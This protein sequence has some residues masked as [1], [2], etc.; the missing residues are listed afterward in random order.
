MARP[1]R[2]ASA[3]RRTSPANPKRPATGEH[4]RQTVQSVRIDDPLLIDAFIRE[5]QERGIDKYDEIWEGVYVVPPL[6]NLPHQDLALAL[7]VILYNVVVLEDRGRVQAG[8]NVSDRREDWEYNCRVPD[9]V[10]V[11][12]EGRAVAC[13]T[14]WMGG[15]DFLIEIK[16][17]GDETEEKIPFY[18]KLKVRELLIIHRDTRELRLYRHN[19]RKL[20][21]VKAAAH[22]GG[23]WLLSQV[24]PLAF[25]LGGTEDNPTTEVSRTDGQPGRW[26]V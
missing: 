22:Q 13:G 1:D 3:A 24:L 8:A 18:A 14:H 12:N 5:R 11:L 26:T 16:S 19:G 6:A 25:R 15:P 4:I 23:K 9:V 2:S 7:A 17:P 21:A 20:V 10:V